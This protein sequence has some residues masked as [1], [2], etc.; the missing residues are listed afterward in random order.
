MAKKIYAKCT[1]IEGDCIVAKSGKL[2]DFPAGT[3]TEDLTC[4]ECSEQLFEVKAPGPD[5][6][7]ILKKVLLIALPILLLGGGAWYM[8]TGDDDTTTTTI[9][10]IPTDTTVAVPPVVVDSIPNETDSTSE[11]TQTTP[12]KED[13]IPITKEPTVKS[14]TAYGMEVPNSKRTVDCDVLYKI[15]DGKGGKIDQIKKLAGCDCGTEKV[16]ASGYKYLIECE[17]GGKKAKLISSN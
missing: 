9:T 2:L 17:N 13:P 7:T 16:F 6:G 12:P 15:W 10:E 5:M 14:A 3:S 11:K 8:I 1:N 4:P